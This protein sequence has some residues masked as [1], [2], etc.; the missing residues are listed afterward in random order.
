MQRFLIIIHFFSLWGLE[1]FTSFQFDVFWVYE[2]ARMDLALVVNT[3]NMK[4]GYKQSDMVKQMGHLSFVKHIKSFWVTWAT[5]FSN[6][7][8]SKFF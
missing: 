1:I 4:A 3:T 7:Y 6:A 5:T 8:G 2:L